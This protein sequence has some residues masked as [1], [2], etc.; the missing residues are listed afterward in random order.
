[1]QHAWIT[2]AL[3]PFAEHRVTSLVPPVFD[4]YARVFHP[5]V[6]YADDGWLDDDGPLPPDEDVTWAEVADFNGRIAHP[7]MEWAS[8]TGAWEF[9]ASD[10]QPGMWNDAPAEGHLPVSVAR[11][12]A[13]VLARHSSTPADC[14]FGLWDGFGHTPATEQTLALPSR[15][16]W[17]LRGPID[18]AASNLGD[19]PAEQSANLWWPD[20][21]A[22]FVA[23]DIDLMTTYV[24]GSAACIADLLVAEGLETAQVP[25]DQRTTWDADTLNPPPRGAPG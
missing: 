12:L 18:L 1:V 23:T 7:A 20:D 11:R 16:Y 15:E 17:L 24:G 25:A 14:W 2:A 13:A 10:D 9:R 6:R 5:A 22:W 21:R 3:H 4:A 8:I 19:E